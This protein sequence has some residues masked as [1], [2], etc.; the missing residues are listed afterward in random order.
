[1]T[2]ILQQDAG[3]ASLGRGHLSRA[4]EEVSPVAT[5]VKASKAEVTGVQRPWWRGTLVGWRRSEGGESESEGKGWD[6][7]GRRV[8]F[9]GP[10]WLRW[11]LFK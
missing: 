1:M 7:G 6:L 2:A 4:W 8:R 5:R 11:L 9:P 3:K 10:G